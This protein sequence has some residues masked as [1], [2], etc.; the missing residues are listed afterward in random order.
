MQEKKDVYYFQKKNKWH[1]CLMVLEGYYNYSDIDIIAYGRK[2]KTCII[3]GFGRILI[4]II[5]LWKEK[6]EM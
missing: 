1:C 3:D 2:K 5:V 4:D 6:K